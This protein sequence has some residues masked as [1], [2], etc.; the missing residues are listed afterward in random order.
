M[1]TLAKL[2]CGLFPF[3][4]VSCKKDESLSPP[5]DNKFVQVSIKSTSEINVQPVSIMYRSNTCRIAK[6]D[7][8]GKEYKEDGY[9]ST[10]QN[11]KS[12]G[13]FSNA[14]IPVDGG[15]ACNWKLSNVTVGFN[16]DKNK[17]NEKINKS[18]KNSIIL[19]FD[20]NLPQNYNGNIKEISSENVKIKRE[21][22]PW[23]DTDY[24]GNH[25][26]SISLIMFGDRTLYSYGV[27]NA[28]V[29]A[30]DLISNLNNAVYSEGPKE[31]SK[32]GS[33]YTVFKYPD[34]TIDTQGKDFP[35]FRKLQSFS[36][37]DD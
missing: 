1:N 10:Q 25:G 14:S 20:S 31:K 29:V 4:I 34:G 35:D 32:N 9:N 36:K 6:Y 13:L 24:M 7:S 12:T 33:N 27:K 18:I 11:I 16:Y 19:V 37:S 8:K 30:I 3:L 21:Y 28:N 22:F 15:G 26:K 2:M 23:I 17:F 5:K